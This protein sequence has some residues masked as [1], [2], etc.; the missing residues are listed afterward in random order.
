MRSEMAAIAGKSSSEFGDFLAKIDAAQE[1]F[2][3]GRP[4][5]FKALWAHTDDITLAGGHG[6]GIEQGWDK[7]AARLDWASSTY[8][9]GDRSNEIIGGFVGGDF[10]YLVRMEIIEAK[11]AGDAERSKQELR[12]TMVFR[13]SAEGWR[14]IHRHADSQSSAQL[15]R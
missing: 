15:P 3:H 12:V 8:Q 9:E 11:I 7:V 13:R 1:D 10:A 14:I 2:A 6:G 4:G 5:D